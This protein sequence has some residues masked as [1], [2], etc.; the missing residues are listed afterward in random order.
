MADEVQHDDA[1]AQSGEGDGRAFDRM[2]NEIG[3][4]LADQAGHISGLQVNKMMF[5]G[6]L[7][8]FGILIMLVAVLLPIVLVAG[9]VAALVAKK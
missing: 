3:S 4:G 2:E 6:G 5:G 8:G 1:P 7:M 9:L